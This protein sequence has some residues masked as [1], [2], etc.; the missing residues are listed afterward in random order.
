[1][2]LVSYFL[3]FIVFYTISLTGNCI[4]VFY[5]NDIYTVIS[6]NEK[7]IIDKANEVRIDY[8]LYSLQRTTAVSPKELLEDIDR[9]VDSSNISDKKAVKEYLKNYYAISKE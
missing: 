3:A 4:R 7:R 5:I 2:A 1:V 9:I 6:D 8:L